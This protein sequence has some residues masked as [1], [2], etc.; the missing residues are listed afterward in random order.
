MTLWG[1]SDKYR[2]YF[3]DERHRDRENPPRPERVVAKTVP[4]CVV[5]PEHGPAMLSAPARKDRVPGTPACGFRLAWRG[6]G[7]NAIRPAT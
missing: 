4:C 5:S 2:A 7:N 6:F 3:S 1:G